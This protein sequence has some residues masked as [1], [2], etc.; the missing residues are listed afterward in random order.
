MGI[1]RGQ[2]PSVREEV[3]ENATSRFRELGEARIVVGS[4]FGDQD[5]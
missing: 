2:G 4:S 5:T 3:P 1:S